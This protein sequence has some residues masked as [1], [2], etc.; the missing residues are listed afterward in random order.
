MANARVRNI[1]IEGAF[2]LP[3]Q[4]GSRLVGVGVAVVVGDTVA[5][6]IAAFGGSAAIEGS[7][8]VEDA[9]SSPVQAVKVDVPVTFEFDIPDAA[10]ADYDIAISS[11]IE[12]IDVVVEKRGGAGAAGNS[13]QVKSTAAAITDVIDTNDADQTLSRPTTINDANSTIAAGG[14]LRVSSIKVGGNAAAK[15][16]VFATKH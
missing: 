16:T 7:V 9:G 1:L 14:I 8:E 15:V 3:P 4:Y 13:V 11:E 5:N 12:V 10:T 2:P 6:V